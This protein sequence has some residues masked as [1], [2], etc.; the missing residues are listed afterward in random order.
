MGDFLPNHNLLINHDSGP[1]Y[2]LDFT[3]VGWAVTSLK[4][5]KFNLLS[6]SRAIDWFR[7]NQLRNIFV[8]SGKA[9]KLFRCLR[10]YYWLSEANFLEVLRAHLWTLCC[11]FWFGGEFWCTKH[12]VVGPLSHLLL[13]TVR[14]AALTVRIRSEVPDVLLSFWWLLIWLLAIE[15]ILLSCLLDICKFLIGVSGFYSR[16]HLWRLVER[17][18][19]CWLASAGCLLLQC[20]LYSAVIESILKRI[21]FSHPHLICI[22][23]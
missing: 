2:L 7:L 11:L 21:H 12:L 17:D 5:C 13:V 15:I 20:Q 8:E 18:E 23:I 1:V 3:F 6:F 22:N 16:L 9:H 14:E 4:S 19:W 10:R